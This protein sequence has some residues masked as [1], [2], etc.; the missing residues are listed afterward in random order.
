[1]EYAPNAQ[2]N[3]AYITRVIGRALKFDEKSRNGG[4]KQIFFS[5]KSGYIRKFRVEAPQVPVKKMLRA[6]YLVARVHVWIS[7]KLLKR[8]SCGLNTIYMGWW[9]VR[10]PLSFRARPKDRD[11]I[12]PKPVENLVLK[13]VANGNH[14]TNSCSYLPNSEQACPFMT[15]FSHNENAPHFFAENLARQR[16]L[17]VA[18][19]RGYDVM[20]I[21][22]ISASRAPVESN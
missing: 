19:S 3:E 22:S 8:S 1:M 2:V 7:Q 20:Y 18:T 6:G 15:T 21:G 4:L 13:K 5:K 14:R 17:Q 10:G 12:E 11:V 9:R 16:A